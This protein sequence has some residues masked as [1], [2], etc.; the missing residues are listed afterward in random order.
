[1]QIRVG[2]PFFHPSYS[3]LSTVDGAI[4]HVDVQII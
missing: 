1:M 2:K 3:D 4:S